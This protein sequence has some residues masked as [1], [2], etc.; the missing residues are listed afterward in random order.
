MEKGLSISEDCALRWW[1]VIFLLVHP[2]GPQQFHWKLAIG[3]KSLLIIIIFYL[4][5]E[6]N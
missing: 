4:F 6:K 3:S 2:F 1:P 5:N